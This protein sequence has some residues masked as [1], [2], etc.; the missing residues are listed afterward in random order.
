MTVQKLRAVLAEW[1]AFLDRLASIGT[2]EALAEREKADRNLANLRAKYRLACV[3]QE[4]ALVKDALDWRIAEKELA[5]ARNVHELMTDLLPGEPPL[6]TEQLQQVG[7]AS[8]PTSED[9]MNY[10]EVAEAEEAKFQ[11]SYA[12]FSTDWPDAEP[13]ETWLREQSLRTLLDLFA[14]RGSEMKK[15]YEEHPQWIRNNSTSG[16]SGDAKTTK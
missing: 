4:V 1:E 5:M 2:P 13:T 8:A 6:T 16:N 9:Y 11:K 12:R 3:V 7:F 15:L 10:L 14:E